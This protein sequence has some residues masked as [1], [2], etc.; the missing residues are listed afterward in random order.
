MQ[1]DIK[2]EPVTHA[3]PNTADNTKALMDLIQGIQTKM[4]TNAN[5]SKSTQENQ[6]E[7][8]NVEAE[9]TNEQNNNSNNQSN[10]KSGFDLS[11]LGSLLGNIDLS[12]ILSGLSGGNSSSNNSGFNLGD[13]DPN[14]IHKFQRVMGSMKKDNPKK[15][16]LL[17][18]KPFLRKERQDKLGEYMTMLTV[19]DAI[20][21]FS[22]KG[23]D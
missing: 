14:T 3:D 17:S 20:D 18:L 2:T 22:S 16:L 11:S 8:I 6:T 15:N 12:S 9:G 10:S 1:D 5:T 13:I 21:I 23:S 7:N 4:N 19:A